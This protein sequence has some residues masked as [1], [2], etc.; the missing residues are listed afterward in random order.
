MT[1]CTHTDAA[2]V[3]V[4]VYMSSV[5]LLDEPMTKPCASTAKCIAV[6]ETEGLEHPGGQQRG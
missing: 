2:N 3:H 6:F 5:G 1:R 4:Y